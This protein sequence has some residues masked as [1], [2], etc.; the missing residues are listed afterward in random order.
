MVFPEPSFYLDH[1]ASAP[2]RAGVL[3]RMQEVASSPG[4]ASS[5]HSFGRRARCY[6]DD[7]R[8][9]VASALGCEPEG[10]IFT[11]GGSEANALILHDKVL[12]D[13]VLHDKVLHDKSLPNKDYFFC[14]AI[15]HPS[16]LEHQTIK[17]S[18]NHPSNHSPDRSLDQPPSR[19]GIISVLPSGI[20]DCR[21]L[22]RMLAA[23]GRGSNGRGSN[24]RV[25]AGRVSLVSIM[26]ANNETGILQPIE[27]VASICREHGVALHCDATQAVG[28]MAISMRDWGVDFL[29]LSAHKLGGPQGVGALLCG[30]RPLS[31]P[32]S[33]RLSSSSMPR[34]S[35]SGVINPLLL[36]GGQESGLRA[37]T[38]N[39]AGIVG[40]A[41]ALR[42]A[43]D[44]LA[45]LQDIAKLRDSF[46][47]RLLA[48]LPH[49]KIVG[50]SVERL[51]NTSCLIHPRFSAEV[52][53]MRCDLS[54]VAISSG[55]ACSSGKVS[56]SH[57]LLAMG[58]DEPTCRRA[59]RVSMG[60][61]TKSEGLELLLELL[62]ADDF[63]DDFVGSPTH[64]SS[65]H[66][67]STHDGLAAS[68][69]KESI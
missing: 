65:A 64:G 19:E 10:V 50:S 21:A 53:L 8:A 26:A 37:G 68:R 28:R 57:V 54:G 60:S 15:E 38:E 56:P 9:T 61:D 35:E 34:L 6:I 12:H 25:S 3:A 1:N 23:A 32:S 43:C 67:G 52:L 20:V 69:A 33:H 44:D 66:D 42:A 18:S 31:R 7:A 4:N 45:R 17:L 5:V 46:E 2:L 27:E 59:V 41:F 62:S 51:A 16:V 30:S 14:S 48:R 39:V 24:G 47:Q 40:F 11:S 29:T 36:G 49:T 13:K 58:Y 22:E 63:A 55:S